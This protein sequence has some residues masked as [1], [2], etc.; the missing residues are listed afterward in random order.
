M[1]NIAAQQNAARQQ[2]SSNTANAVGA[3]VGG[4]MAVGSL[5]DWWK[6]GGKVS[7]AKLIRTGGIKKY[8]AGG[9]VGQSIEDYEQAQIID[10]NQPI[11]AVD[12]DQQ[13]ADAAAS[14]KPYVAPPKKIGGL[15]WM[16]IAARM[17]QQAGQ[18]A[19]PAQE[20]GQARMPPGLTSA[21]KG[22]TSTP[23]V[24]EQHML[25]GQAGGQQQKM[26]RGFFNIETP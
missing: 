3:A 20:G 16:R 14:Y 25:G 15:P 6:D 17:K 1:A 10:A 26:Q 9:Q 5:M 8:A 2:A 12:I 7:T 22:A 4:T 24:I 21:L 23:A 11:N 18:A 13:W 19:G